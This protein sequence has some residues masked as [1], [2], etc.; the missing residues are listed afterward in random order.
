MLH[1]HRQIKMARKKQ[2]SGGRT[3][4]HVPDSSGNIIEINGKVAIEEALMKYN[5][6]KFRS[7]SDTPF[8]IDTKYK[9]NDI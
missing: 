9:C 4:L 8:A 2:S 3:K 1:S 7:A 5:E 6:S